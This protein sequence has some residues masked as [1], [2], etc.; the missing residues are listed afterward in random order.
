MRPLATDPGR[1]ACSPRPPTTHAVRPPHHALPCLSFS[2]SLSACPLARP[3]K[4]RIRIRMHARRRRHRCTC[5]CVHVYTICLACLGLFCTTYLCGCNFLFV[6]P[7]HPTRR[8]RISNERMGTG[9]TRLGPVRFTGNGYQEKLRPG[10]VV[11]FYKL[12]RVL[13]GQWGRTATSRWIDPSKAAPVRIVWPVMHGLPDPSRVSIII[14][15][16]SV[17]NS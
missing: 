4:D 1:R 16:H 8:I 2:A 15:T 3:G 13:C 6:C 9:E 11:N 14:N 10:L 5:V 12:V 17:L 7:T